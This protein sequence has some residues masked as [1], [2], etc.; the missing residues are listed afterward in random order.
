LIVKKMFA[1]CLALAVCVSSNPDGKMSGKQAFCQ[2]DCLEI[3]SFSIPETGCALH[4]DLDAYTMTVYVDGRL[5]RTFPVSGGSDETPSPVGTWLVVKI[6]DWGEG[7][8]GSWIGLNV[9]WG[10]YGIHGTL[11]PWL[12]GKKHVSHGCIRMRDEDVYEI[13][14]LVEIGSIV[15]IKHD[16]LPFRNMGKDVK[17]SDVLKAQNM[18]AN[19]G[20]YTGPLDGIFGDG[21]LRAVKGF[22]RTYGLRADGVVGRET[23]EKIVEQEKILLERIP[24]EEALPARRPD[25][26]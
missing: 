7:Y 18:L 1:L 26:I 6:S 13:K 24:P 5:Y 22:Q 25:L 16:A 20:F 9:P 23:Y 2:W 17:G 3:S 15:H 12:V 4:I 19:L 14:Q 21:L 11:K 8:G 10:I